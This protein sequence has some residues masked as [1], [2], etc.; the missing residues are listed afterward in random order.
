MRRAV[1]SALNRSAS[2]YRSTLTCKDS[3]D[4]VLLY[5]EGRTVYLHAKKQT[6]PWKSETGHEHRGKGTSW[7]ILS[8]YIFTKELRP[9]C[10]SM[11]F[12]RAQKGFTIGGVIIPPYTDTKKELL[13]LVARA[14]LTAR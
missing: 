10:H 2:L 12:G 13:A 14:G 4:E 9:A 11:Y 3:R 5:D 7:M 1:K 8:G 6:G